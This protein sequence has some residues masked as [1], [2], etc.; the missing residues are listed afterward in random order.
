MRTE[1]QYDEDDNQR[2]FVAGFE[3]ELRRL[4]ESGQALTS[5]QEESLLGA[6]GAASLGEHE[7]A[8]GMLLQARRARPGTAPHQREFRRE[9]MPLATLRRRFERLC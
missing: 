7:L 6:L 1:Q 5:W 3:C 2:R 4:D 9:P 8:C